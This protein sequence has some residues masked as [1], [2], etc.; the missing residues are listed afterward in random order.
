[1][2]HGKVLNRPFSPP[3]FKTKV[4]CD[5]SRV[6]SYLIDRIYTTFLFFF[7]P[8]LQIT[9]RI[10]TR[11]IN[12]C[13]AVINVTANL[14]QT[15]KIQ[16]ALWINSVLLQCTLFLHASSFIRCSGLFCFV[17]FLGI[18]FFFFSAA[19]LGMYNVRNASWESL[20]RDP[21]PNRLQVSHKNTQL[22]FFSSFV[23]FF[24]L[25]S[26]SAVSLHSS[27]YI[28]PSPESWETFRYQYEMCEKLTQKIITIIRI[29]FQQQNKIKRNGTYHEKSQ[30]KSGKIV[31]MTSLV[32]CPAW[33]L[34]AQN[35]MISRW[36][37]R[38]DGSRWVKCFLYY[39]NS[40]KTKNCGCPIQAVRKDQ[41]ARRGV[42]WPFFL[43]FPSLYFFLFKRIWRRR[44][45]RD[46]DV[47]HRR[48]T[49]KS[50]CFEEFHN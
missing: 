13:S 29:K 18:S 17:H 48:S 16:N 41:A 7:S 44:R 31:L 26:P 2:D 19:S 27:E 42:A 36:V 30:I 34:K 6:N 4:Y 47:W 39:S 24:F 11:H 25:S 12:T 21:D 23:C 22:F 15:E 14:T 35:L 45:Q 50:Q 43:F 37:G 5:N 32:W 3:A 10:G 20:I 28:Q 33:Q 1:M 40:V 49:G 9:I 38:D 46:P 8:P